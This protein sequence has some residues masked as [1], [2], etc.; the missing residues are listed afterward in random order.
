MSKIIR[1]NDE[2]CRLLQKAKENWIEELKDNPNYDSFKTIINNDNVM[3]QSALRT[4]ILLDIGF[5]ESK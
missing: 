1:L 3:I 5:I 4:Q 2:T